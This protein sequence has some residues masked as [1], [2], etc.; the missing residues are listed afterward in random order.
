MRREWQAAAD[1][2]GRAIAL[3]PYYPVPY[4]GLGVLF[5]RERNVSGAISSYKR[6]I[7]LEPGWGAPYALLGLALELE[8]KIDAASEAYHVCE[9]RA[10][11]NPG[12]G[13]AASARAEKIARHPPTA[14]PTATRPPVPTLTPVPT[15]RIYLV[16]KGDTLQAIAEEL[17]VS[18]HRLV[19]INRL[20]D[21]NA[22]R[23]GQLLIIPESR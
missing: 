15:S 10:W 22:I 5:A 12:L 19:E 21:P 13:E 7:A 1:A 4:C 16:K 14:V 18:L 3:D 9:Q 11:L 6:A 2:F 17:G 8:A 20:E 23:T